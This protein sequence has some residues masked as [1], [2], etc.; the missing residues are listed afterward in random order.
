MA[1][2]PAGDGDEPPLQGG[3][4]GLAAADAVPVKIAADVGCI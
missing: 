4:H 3:D 1:D 2:Q